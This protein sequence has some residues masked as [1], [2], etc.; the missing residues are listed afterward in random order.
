MIDYSE[1]IA[2]CVNTKVC[3][4]EK[5]LEQVFRELDVNG[6]NELSMEELTDYFETNTEF[7]QA[8]EIVRIFKDMDIDRSGTVSFAEFSTFMKNT[9]FKQLSNHT[10]S[11]KGLSDSKHQGM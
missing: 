4:Y 2:S 5:Y 11:F 1:F 7:L 6:D 9:L 10:A 8:E 3:H